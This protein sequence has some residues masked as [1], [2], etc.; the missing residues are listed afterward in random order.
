M[1]QFRLAL[2]ITLF[3]LPFAN[4]AQHTDEINSN[5]PGLS[6]SA[7]AVGKTVIQV[8]TGIYGIKENHSL[9]NYDGNGFGVDM[10]IRF[11][12]I[13]ERLEFIG[14]VQYQNEDFTTNFTYYNK[15]ALKQ[16][17]IGLKYLI[18]DP[19]KDWESKVNVKSWRA[20]HSFN[21]RQLIPAV[22]FYVGGN[23]IKPGNPYYIGNDFSVT[24]KAMLITQNHLGDGSW[25]LVSNIIADY[26]LSTYTSYGYILTLT[27]GFNRKW[28]GFVENQGYNS[29][30]YSDAI[31]RGGAAFLVNKNIQV[32]ASISTSLKTTPSILYGGVG[33]SWR[34]DDNYQEIRI[35]PEDS[36]QNKKAAK[37][38][39]KIKKG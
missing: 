17:N 37:K 38:A 31:V 12:A 22:S 16:T 36:K 13:D 1:F 2:I 9:L 21:W 28:S 26:I 18:Y 32:D 27:K 6:M 8:E 11:G 19:Y 23:Y 7:Y 24:P 5:R 30:Y 15:S 14:T 34:Y 10:T 35:K 33:F 4:Y 25:V 39:K 20:N 29:D 3:T